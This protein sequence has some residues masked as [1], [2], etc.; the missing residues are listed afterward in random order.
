MSPKPVL[1]VHG[2]ANHDKE[3]FK[4]RV[5]ALQET[6]RSHLPDVQLIPVFWGDLGG[7]SGSIQDCLP[8]LKE[9]QWTTRAEGILSI[10]A[11]G[12]EVRAEP[13][14]NNEERAALIA[15]SASTAELVR[16]EP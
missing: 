7:S 9:G 6:I 14:L 4:Q 1:V 8:Q 5:A 11:T 2:I 13:T 12:P 16:S 15:G 3:A 10:Q